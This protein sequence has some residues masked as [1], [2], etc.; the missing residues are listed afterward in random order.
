MTTI[1]IP[2]Q[3]QRLVFRGHDLLD[4][5]LL[6]SRRV[7]DGVTVHLLLKKLQV[8]QQQQQMPN[9]GQAQPNNQLIMHLQ[10]PNGLP[11]NVQAMQLA[12]GGGHPQHGGQQNAPLDAEATRRLVRTTTLARAVKLFAIIEAVFLIIWSVS[13]W[14]LA[15]GVLLAIAGYYGAVHFRYRFVM[16]YFVYLVLSIAL[17]GVWIALTDSLL[18][19]F[20]LV[21][22]IVLEIYIGRV[23]IRFLAL[24]KLL[25]P[26]DRVYLMNIRRPRNGQRGAQQRMQR[27]QHA[28]AHAAAQLAAVGAQRQRNNP[29]HPG[30]FVIRPAQLQPAQHHIIAMPVVQ[31]G[32]FG[33]HQQP[34]FAPAGAGGQQQPAAFQAP[35]PLAGPLANNNNNNNHNNNGQ[36]GYHV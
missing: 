36:Q 18:T 8:Q 4:G 34:M 11:Y 15:L 14:P 23:V 9:F 19:I 27:H 28:A 30:G 20:I 6:A 29:H 33:G 31:Q 16:C 32:G 2:I 10:Q 25:T 24:I 13:F 3:L 1:D 22:G 5:E 26:L 7:R 35:Q 12:A 17:R 21:L